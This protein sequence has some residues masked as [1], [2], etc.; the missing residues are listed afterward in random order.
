[1][2]S[3]NSSS[4]LNNISCQRSDQGLEKNA[5]GLPLLRDQGVSRPSSDLSSELRRCR[6]P[7]FRPSC[8]DE[9]DRGSQKSYPL[10]SFRHHVP[11]RQ[12]A[13]SLA[14]SHDVSI[15]PIP[16]SLQKLHHVHTLT[17]HLDHP[18]MLQHAPGRSTAFG[19][20]FETKKVQC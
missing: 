13:K 14:P 18:R 9:S 2:G 6:A 11:L 16:D 12:P 1:V 7:V 17:F 15:L 4:C 8:V 20:F 5:S 3:T 19:L 10:Q